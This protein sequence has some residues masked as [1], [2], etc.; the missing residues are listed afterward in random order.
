MNIL[1]ISPYFFPAVGGVETHLNDLCKYLKEKKNI[2]FVR[3]YKAFGVKDRG[4]TYEGDRF[5]K[6]HRLWW[7]DFNL[8]FILEKYSGLKFLYLF[9]GLFFDC[10]LF[11]FK[12]GKDI[13]IIQTHGFIAALIAVILGKIFNKKVV[14]NTHVGFNLNDNFMTRIIRW[15]LLNSDK[16][17][18]LTPSVKKSLTNLGVPDV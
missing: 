10:L 15:T 12:K 14:I 7:P 13:D 18:V 9:I 1:L 5:L 3:T 6:I 16:I 4:E 11:L 8:I 17:L 2:I